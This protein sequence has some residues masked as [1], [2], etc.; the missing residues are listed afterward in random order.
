LHSARF[1]AASHPASFK[2]AAASAARMRVPQAPSA[3]SALCYRVSL[4]GEL[5]D[6]QGLDGGKPPVHRFMVDEARQLIRDGKTI[7]FKRIATV[8]QAL[9]LGA[10]I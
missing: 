9:A 3:P 2:A 8:G 10:A 6:L 4:A 5:P 1:S 7:Y